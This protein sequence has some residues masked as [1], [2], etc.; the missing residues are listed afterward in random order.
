MHKKDNQRRFNREFCQSPTAFESGLSSISR[1]TLVR[2][3]QRLTLCQRQQRYSCCSHLVED[4]T[5]DGNADADTWRLSERTDGSVRMFDLTV[6]D[7]KL[8]G[9]QALGNTVNNVV[10]FV[11]WAAWRCRSRF[12]CAV[13]PFIDPN[14]IRSA[15]LERKNASSR[16]G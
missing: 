2:P 6:K 11:S 4:L 12:G 9:F 15:F 10:L 1:M 16:N 14:L 13:G 8:E 5:F 3:K 7:I